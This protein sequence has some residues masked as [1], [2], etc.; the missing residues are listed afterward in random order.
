MSDGVRKHSAR[1]ML[2]WILSVDP[3][4]DNYMKIPVLVSDFEYGNQ[5][6]SCLA[7]VLDFYRHLIFLEGRLKDIYDEIPE[8]RCPWEFTVQF[9]EA[10]VIITRTARTEP[11]DGV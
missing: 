2:D 11:C 3:N 6:C 8:H 7:M 4:W 5:T 9:T 1:V 10:G